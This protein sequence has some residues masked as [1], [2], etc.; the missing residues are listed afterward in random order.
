[1]EQTL[2]NILGVFFLITVLIWG[3][4]EI[5]KIRRHRF[6][7]SMKRWA[8]PHIGRRMLITNITPWKEPSR[9]LPAVT[10]DMK[11]EEGNLLTLNLYTGH[12]DLNSLANKSLLGRCVILQGEENP[13]MQS[14]IGQR[15]EGHLS[16]WLQLENF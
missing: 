3:W 15:K 10:V 7:E 4:A 9:N 8:A 12:R 6:N 2:N 11:Y 5:Q 16:Y 14:P 13:Y 1:M